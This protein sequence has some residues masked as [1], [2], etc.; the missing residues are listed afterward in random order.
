MSNFITSTSS[1]I[2]VVFPTKNIP[3]SISFD[4]GKDVKKIMVDLP[5]LS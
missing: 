1:I 4:F 3:T 2:S 5:N